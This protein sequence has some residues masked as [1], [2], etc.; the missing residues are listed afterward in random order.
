MI[1]TVKGYSLWL[2]PQGQTY[3]R[4]NTIIKNLHKDYLK[5]QFL[6]HVTLLEELGLSR[7]EMIDKTSRLAERL[8]PFV[9]RFQGPVHQGGTDGSAFE[10]AYGRKAH[11]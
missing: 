1:N 5:P 3:E 4:L 11:I 9:I 8:K 2:M 7:E 6:P 10:S